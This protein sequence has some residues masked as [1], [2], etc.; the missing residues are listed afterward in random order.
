MRREP[1]P[2]LDRLLCDLSGCEAV[3][4]IRLQSLGKSQVTVDCCWEHFAALALRSAKQW[5]GVELVVMTKD[6]LRVA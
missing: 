3:A 4:T 5:V 6:G 2:E 1:W